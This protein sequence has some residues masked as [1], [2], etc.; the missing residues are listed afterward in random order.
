MSLTCSSACHAEQLWSIYHPSLALSNLNELAAW[1]KM[2]QNFPNSS[3]SAQIVFIFLFLGDI[4]PS[5]WHR[6]G[7]PHGF[8]ESVHGALQ[9][10]S[11]ISY[12]FV[13]VLA[14]LLF[15]IVWCLS[16]FLSLHA[17]LWELDTQ[18]CCTGARAKEQEQKTRAK[19]FPWKKLRTRGLR[20]LTWND[21]PK[22]F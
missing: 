15:P 22:S 7:S 2:I 13:A 10:R 4:F 9:K 6:G 19:C 3:F 11:L 18:Q 1:R 17:R 8:A 21:W 12:Y 16:N 14:Q 20:L 5:L